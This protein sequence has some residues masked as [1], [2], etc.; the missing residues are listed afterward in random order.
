MDEKLTLMHDIFSL[1]LLI[2]VEEMDYVLKYGNYCLD[3]G[4]MDDPDDYDWCDDVDET[5]YDPYMGCDFYD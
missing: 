2:F 4:F 1:A 3:D 5:F